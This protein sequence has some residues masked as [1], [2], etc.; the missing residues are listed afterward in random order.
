M[1]TLGLHIE[2]PT[3]MHTL[4]YLVALNVFWSLILI[5]APVLNIQLNNPIISIVAA[6]F[7]WHTSCSIIGIEA[8]VAYPKNIIF[9]LIGSLLTLSTISYFIGY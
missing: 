9:H 7:I 6:C 5:I 8:S 1:T 4:I 2:K 3:L